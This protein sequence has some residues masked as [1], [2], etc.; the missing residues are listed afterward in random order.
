M[1]LRDKLPKGPIRKAL[2]SDDETYVTVWLF[3]NAPTYDSVRLLKDIDTE[4][5]GVRVTDKK[6]TASYKHERPLIELTLD[7]YP[8]SLRTEGQLREMGKESEWINIIEAY[9]TN[10]Y[11]SY[12]E[13]EE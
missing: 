4:L 12:K 7:E 2:K 10:I 8:L 9:G 5:A 3:K 13:E 6:I 11:N 1:S